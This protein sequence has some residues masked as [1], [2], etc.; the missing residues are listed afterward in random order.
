M[1][2]CKLV[3][4][5]WDLLVEKKNRVLCDP[6]LPKSKSYE[7]LCTLLRQQFS[8][9]S[10]IFKEPASSCDDVLKDRLVSGLTRG[11]ILDRVCEEDPT[12]KLDE[13]IKVALK[14]EAA[15]SSYMQKGHLAKACR[16][17]S[18]YVELKQEEDSQNEKIPD[19]LEMCYFSNNKYVEPVKIEVLVNN[20]LME[21]DAGAGVNIRVS[22]YTK[23]MVKPEGEFLAQVKYKDIEVENCRIIVVR[24]GSAYIIGRD[25]LKLFKI[26]IDCDD[27]K[28]ALNIIEKTDNRDLNILL[29]KYEAL[30]KEELGCFIHEKVDLKIE[31]NVKPVFVKPRPI[32]F[33]FKEQINKELN[34]LE[35][36]GVISKIESAD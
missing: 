28:R 24:D 23:D 35:K 14:K 13:L 3:G 22:M 19:L 4:I 15:L 26:I 5:Q 9:R 10:S 20:E 32:P 17:K 27:S 6:D 11:P 8:K 16:I 36:R 34:E 25:L 18:H 2:V 21:I 12:K 1:F 33:A 30:F 7:E 31:P 29:K